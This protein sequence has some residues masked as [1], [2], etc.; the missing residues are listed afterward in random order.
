LFKPI[1]YKGV[2]VVNRKTWYK[3]SEN[4]QTAVTLSLEDLRSIN[5]DESTEVDL[6]VQV[7]FEDPQRI[8][9]LNALN[10]I[11]SYSSRRKDSGMMKAYLYQQ[12]SRVHESSLSAVANS[13][14]VYFAIFKINKNNGVTDKDGLG[15][16]FIDVPSEC[17][18]PF[19]KSFVNTLRLLS[20]P[21]LDLSYAE[22]INNNAFIEKY[23][24]NDKRN[25]FGTRRLF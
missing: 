2:P 11:S 4:N 23:I 19:V 22:P 13:D 14:G 15:F 17:L 16:I 7:T 10:Q 1:R 9:R 25:A 5:L 24:N 8:A 6:Y 18:N 21:N 20:D 3:A 12:G